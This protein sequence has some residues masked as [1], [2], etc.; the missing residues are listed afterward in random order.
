MIGNNI[1]YFNDKDQKVYKDGD[2]SPLNFGET[3]EEIQLV[4]D[5]VVI[6]FNTTLNYSYRSIVYDKDGDVAFIL[7]R[8]MSVISADSKRMTY[9]DEFDKKVFLVEMK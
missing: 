3:G 1:Y 2:K 7:P 5:Y 8:K 6:T 9:F 4:G